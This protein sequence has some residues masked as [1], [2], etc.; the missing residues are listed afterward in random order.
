MTDQE[1]V[2]LAMQYDRLFHKT[3][4]QFA[5]DAA[6]L[7]ERVID[8]GIIYTGVGILF[9]YL[10]GIALGRSWWGF[11]G[12]IAPVALFWLRYLLKWRRRPAGPP[13]PPGGAS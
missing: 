12:A 10:F 7:N 4:N 1:R 9:G 5:T 11:A 13:E 2:E 8:R 3:L 6:R